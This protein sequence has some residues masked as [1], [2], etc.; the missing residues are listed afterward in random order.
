M[1]F[2]PA[3]QWFFVVFQMSFQVK[4]K[5]IYPCIV[6]CIT[7]CCCGGS[8]SLLVRYFYVSVLPDNNADILAATL[9][10]S[11]CN[12]WSLI[13]SSMVMISLYPSSNRF[14]QKHNGLFNGRVVSMTKTKYCFVVHFLYRSIKSLKSI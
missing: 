4:K 9:L 2:S 5:C 3:V 12:F 8:I 11:C 7:L 14:S 1:F 10:M 13:L 6:S